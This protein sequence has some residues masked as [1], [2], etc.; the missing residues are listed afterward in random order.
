MMLRDHID[1]TG[2][3]I[4]RNVIPLEEVVKARKH[5]KSEK[6]LYI[7]LEN[8]INNFIIGTVSDKFGTDLICSKYRVSNKNNANDAAT[9]HRDIHVHTDN[10]DKNIPVYT[11]LNYMDGGNIQLIPGSHDYPHMGIRQ[12]VDFYYN[13]SEVLTLG[14]TDILIFRSTLLHRGV[15]YIAQDNRRLI[16]CFDCIPSNKFEDLNSQ[17]LHT[18]CINQC[19]NNFEKMMIML[20]KNAFLINFVDFINYYNVASGYGYKE[21]GV[22]KRL[23]GDKYKYI[24]TESNNR[25]INKLDNAGWG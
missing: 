8:Y 18:P 15:F 2:Y 25:R 12:M 14:P 21:Y 24:S 6:V 23:Y 11:V 17:I 19:L 10:Y 9:Y 22:L 13:K 5:I 3:K 16:Q 7:K 20:S 4:I 1:K